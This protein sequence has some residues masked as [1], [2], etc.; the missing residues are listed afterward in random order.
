MQNTKQKISIADLKAVTETVK[1]LK[2]E[3]K[4]LPERSVDPE[5]AIAPE[6]TEAIIDLIE[7]AITLFEDYGNQFRPIERLRKNG[8]GIRNY[9][10]TSI[11]YANASRNP[12]FVPSYLDMEVFNQAISD[13]RSKRDII[14][15]IRQLNTFVRDG[16]RVPADAAYSYALEYYGALREATR[17]GAVGAE[18]EFAELRPFFRRVR[19]MSTPPTEAQIERD[20]HALLHGTKDGELIVKNESPRTTGGKREVID[21]THKE[22]S[23]IRETK[24]R[25]IDD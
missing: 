12:Q 3:M 19:P 5:E 16:M 4:S 25:D 8:L 18:A 10:F 15:W 1:K 17:R 23:S 20:L 14:G 9:G 2:T 6:V 21:E 7:E 24:E 22:Q 11:A 13:F